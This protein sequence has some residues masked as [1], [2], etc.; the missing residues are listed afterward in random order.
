MPILLHDRHPN[1]LKIARA[2]ISHRIDP[3]TKRSLASVGV[4]NDHIRISA[5][6]QKITCKKRIF[7]VPLKT[8]S[9]LQ[10]QTAHNKAHTP[11]RIWLA[12]SGSIPSSHVLNN[13]WM[14]F[15]GVMLNAIW[16][17]RH[18]FFAKG[19]SRKRCLMDSHPD[20]KNYIL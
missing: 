4:S 10:F 1:Q 11:T 12:I 19:Q 6:A 20:H 3:V 17:D 18:N 2:T 7:V 15:G 9:F 14:I 13:V 16:T 8:K 5:V